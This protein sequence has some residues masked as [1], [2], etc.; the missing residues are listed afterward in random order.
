MI[1]PTYQKKQ[2]GFEPPC[3]VGQVSQTVNH[4]V[5]LCARFHRRARSWRSDS[6]RTFLARTRS[7]GRCGRRCST[8][9]G[10]PVAQYRSQRHPVLCTH[11]EP[12][13][14]LALQSPLRQRI[15]VQQCSR[16]QHGLSPF[17][18]SVSV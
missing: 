9:H 11:L 15:P 17:P 7:C 10:M 2:G 13:P 8:A 14:A 3:W 6:H 5:S 18:Y 1:G 12:D 4:I 16:D